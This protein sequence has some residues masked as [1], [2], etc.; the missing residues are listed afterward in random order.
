MSDE[1]LQRELSSLLPSLINTDDAGPFWNHD[2]TPVLENEMQHVCY[3]IRVKHNIPALAGWNDPWQ[4]Q[5]R[6]ILRHM[7]ASEVTAGVKS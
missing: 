1:A 7:A 6:H 4:D 3:L 2:G 5:A